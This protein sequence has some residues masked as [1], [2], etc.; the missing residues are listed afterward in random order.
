MPGPFKRRGK[1]MFE[2]NYLCEI[3]V[4]NIHSIATPACQWE[5]DLMN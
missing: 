2:N 1:T 5:L 3:T 4:P